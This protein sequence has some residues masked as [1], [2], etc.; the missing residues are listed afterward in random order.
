[1]VR[2]VVAGDYVGRHGFVMK[3]PD[4][5]QAYDAHQ[6]RPEEITQARIDGRCPRCGRPIDVSEVGG[7]CSCRF[8]F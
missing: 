6:V 5:E 1:M 7:R 2:S 8:A 3:L 4:W